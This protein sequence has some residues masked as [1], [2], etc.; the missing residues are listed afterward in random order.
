MVADY[1]DSDEKGCRV[2][3]DSERYVVQGN[4]VFICTS[5]SEILEV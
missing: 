2:Y 3:G 1:A 5:G 4:A